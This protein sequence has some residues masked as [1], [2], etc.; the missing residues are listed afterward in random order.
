MSDLPRRI[1]AARAYAGLSQIE[2]AKVLE[3]GES[4]YK[5]SELGQRSIEIP[6]RELLAIAEACDVPMW[7]LE[8]GWDGWRASTIEREGRAGVKDLEQHEGED[9]LS[10]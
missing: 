8:G 5:L 2:M 9:Q 1:R 3:L 7:F 4:T 6:R 10:G